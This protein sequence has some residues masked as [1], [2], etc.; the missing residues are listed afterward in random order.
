V[1]AL[2]VGHLERRPERGI[3]RLAAL[4]AIALTVLAFGLAIANNALR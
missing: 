4:G 3:D 1:A 2:V